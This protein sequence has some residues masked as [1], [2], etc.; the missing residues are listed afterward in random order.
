[1]AL[2]FF[3][4]IS[5]FAFICEAY[6][7]DSETIVAKETNETLTKDYLIMMNHITTYGVLIKM[8]SL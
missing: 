5:S 2:F 3:L 8:V 1:M 7:K 4:T 6:R